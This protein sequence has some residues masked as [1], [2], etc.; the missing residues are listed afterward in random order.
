MC[1]RDRSLPPLCRTPRTYGMLL[2]N[3]KKSYTPRSHNHGGLARRRVVVHTVFHQLTEPVPPETASLSLSVVALMIVAVPGATVSVVASDDVR[4]G[5][6]S[7]SRVLRRRRNTYQM[8]KN[9]QSGAWQ[10]VQV[11]LFLWHQRQSRL[12][13]LTQ[14]TRHGTTCKSMYIRS[15]QSTTTRAYPLLV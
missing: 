9:D 11:C 3:E 1:M 6:R 8:P 10:S 7:L 12:N 13:R 15:R 2:A 14:L 5:A 4:D